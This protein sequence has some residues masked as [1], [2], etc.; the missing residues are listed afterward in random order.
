M[1]LHSLIEFYSFTF[2]LV[3]NPLTTYFRLVCFIFYVDK[4]LSLYHLLDS[5]F[6]L[7][8]LKKIFILFVYL[9]NLFIWLHHVLFVACRI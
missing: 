8:F 6:F 3:L 4:E 9:F 5:S 2:Y 1:H 7:Q